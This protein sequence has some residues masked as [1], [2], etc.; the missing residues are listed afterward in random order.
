MKVNTLL[1]LRPSD[2][3]PYVEYLRQENVDVDSDALDAGIDWWFTGGNVVLN[4]IQID[5]VDYTGPDW[6]KGKD[7]CV[8]EGSQVHAYRTALDE[9]DEEEAE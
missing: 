5:G 7:T 3:E 4:R 2:S 6:P 8:K 9:S 1:F